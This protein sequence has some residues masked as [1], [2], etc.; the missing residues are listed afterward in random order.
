MQYRHAGVELNGHTSFGPQEVYLCQEA[1]SLVELR[2]QWTQAV[3]ESQQYALHL[4]SLVELQL[5]QVVAKLHHL[6]GFHE[7]RLAC[8]ALVLYQAAYLA[9]VGGEQRYH[10]P[11][12][13]D[14]HLG[15]RRCPA[16]AFGTRQGA[17]DLRV[18]L[19]GLACFGAP[20]LGEGGGGVVVELAVVVDELAQQRVDDVELRALAAIAK[21]HLDGLVAQRLI[22][23]VF[24]GGEEVVAFPYGA[25]R[26]FKVK[27]ALQRYHRVAHAQVC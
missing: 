12:V 2:Q 22:L 23:H 11:P 6:A 9:A 24:F 20:Y 10:G 8:G 13:A 4:V 17:V 15:V 7:G 25:Q 3:A 1:V 18:H 14:R 5:T 27:E 26:E 16:F 21:H 19:R